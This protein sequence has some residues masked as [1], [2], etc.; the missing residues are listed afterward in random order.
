M[1]PNK[2]VVAFALP[3]SGPE[4]M[5]FTEAAKAAAEQGEMPNRSRWLTDAALSVKPAARDL[6]AATQ[7]V[8]GNR[9]PIQVTMLPERRDALKARAR[10]MGISAAALVRACAMA[11][12]RRLG[13]R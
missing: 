6:E 1:A 10:Q 13:V 5:L 11:E 12:A 3:L 7:D 8:P 2:H 9:R 4:G